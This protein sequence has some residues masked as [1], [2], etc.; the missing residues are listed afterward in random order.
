MP[1]NAASRPQLTQDARDALDRVVRGELGAGQMGA[2]WPGAWTGG[3][4]FSLA[5][6]AFP[7]PGMV[8]WFLS[9]YVGAPDTGRAEKLAWQL[10]F[11]FRGHR[12]ALSLQ[13]FGLRL[14]VDGDLDEESASQLV[15][16]LIRK[17]R[18]AMQVVE[19]SVFAPFARAQL[20]A[21]NLTIRNQAHHLRGMYEH[22]RA[23]AEQVREPQ[24]TG[25]SLEDVMN[26]WSAE[27]AEEQDRFFNA[28]AMVNAYFSWLEHILVLCRPLTPPRPAP[29]TLR[30]FIGKRWRD[31]FRDVFDVS[32]PGRAK[33]VHDALHDVAEEHKNTYSHGGFDKRD[34]AF[35][36][37]SEL[38]AMPARL[39]DDVLGQVV[40]MPLGQT[41]TVAAILA[42]L[43]DAD[44]WLRTGPT[45]YGVM[46]AEL[47]LDLPLQQEHLDRAFAAMTSVDDFRAWLDAFGQHVDDL[48]NMDW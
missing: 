29:D 38:G 6:G 5:F 4:K 17:L 34:G 47:G 35:L 14:Y 16:E 21:G 22:F 11:T 19:R 10:R 33:S 31:K 42:V 25:R 20:D 30:D 26:A 9:E 3:H 45:Q 28:V 40:G 8:A 24:A 32:Q 12:C 2:A 27:R 18:S 41:P 37:H 39:S 48:S 1:G 43:D 23:L 13:K 7:V 44:D 15:E 36:I 46:Y